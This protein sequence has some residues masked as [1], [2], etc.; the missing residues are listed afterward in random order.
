MQASMWKV[1]IKIVFLYFVLNPITVGG[2]FM[3]PP[4]VLFPSG[5]QYI[6]LIVKC[7]Y[8]FS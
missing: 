5:I 3:P 7:F 8:D 1:D 2:A 6:A 4:P